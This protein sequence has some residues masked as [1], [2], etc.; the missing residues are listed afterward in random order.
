MKIKQVTFTEFKRFI[1][2]TITGLQESTKLVVLV[3]SNGSGKSSVFE[4]FNHWYKYNGYRSFGEVD[5]YLKKGA[6]AS[7]NRDWYNRAVAVDFWGGPYNQQQIHKAFYFRTAYRNDADFTTRRLEQ[8]GD[9]SEGIRFDK[10]ISSDASVANNYQRLASLTL[11]GIYSGDYD[12]SSVKDLRE[13]IIGRVQ[14]SLSRV[15]EDLQLES[16]GN[17]LVNGSFYFT[18]GTSKGFHYKNLSAG[19]K[20]AFDLILDMAVQSQYY[21]KAIYCID[22]PET[23]MHTSLQSKLLAELYAMIPQEGQMWIA[24]HSIGMLKKAREIEAANPGTVAFLDFTDIDFDSP[25]EIKPTKI[26]STIWKRFMD[27]AFGDFADLVA[28]QAIVFCEGNPLATNNKNFDAQIYQCIFN[29]IVPTP[30]FASVG[31]CTD[32]EDEDNASMRIVRSILG[33][34]KII[35]LVDRDNRSEQEI[36]DANARGIRVLSR[37]HLESYLLD[38]E[39][40]QALCVKQNQLEAYNDVLSIKQQAISNAVSRGKDVTDIKSAAGEMIDGIRRRLSLRNAGNRTSSFLRDTIAPL[41]TPDT[42]VYQQL[43]ADIFGEG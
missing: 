18:K 21:P 29:G 41:I 33:H 8:T 24:T 36:A 39:V 16:L 6:S 2:L 7:F 23:H 25:A 37:R 28:P 30:C 34:S 1:K 9:P 22:E 35:R 10:L 32:V 15:F 17:P 26:D 31:S 19:E 43:K 20:S 13:L 27:L 4:G 40:L 38:D 12:S 5:F 14:S 42:T 3:G 11:Q